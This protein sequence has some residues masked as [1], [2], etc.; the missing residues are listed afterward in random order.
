MAYTVLFSLLILAVGFS[1]G[2]FLKSRGSAGTAASAAVSNSLRLSP[3]QDAKLVSPLILCGVTDIKEFAEFQPLQ[4]K[5]SD[6]LA[7]PGEKGVEASV[8]YRDLLA[9]RWFGINQDAQ[10]N[11]ASL[12]KVAIMIAYY[13][14]AEKNPG[15]LTQ[16]IAYTQAAHD[17][18]K[19]VPNQA[20]SMLTVGKS[21]SADELIKSMIVDSD[22]GAKDLL[23]ASIDQ[24][25]L[26]E[27]Y[28]DLGIQNPVT[29]GA[30]YVISAK[31]YALFFRILYNATY[32]WQTYSE[33][34]LELLAQSQ[35]KDGLAAGIPEG[36]TIAHKFGEYVGGTPDAPE[37]ELHD[38]GIVYN[39]SAPFLIC[40]MT[41]GSD[42][43][44]LQTTISSITKLVYQEVA[45]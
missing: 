42:I 39:K 33:K 10:Y 45:K 1:A 7:T 40:V 17:E 22:N 44:K 36:T 15:T 37:V 43:G 19:D 41:K 25:S 29:K 18:I 24:N 14:E 35:F 12:L 38:C 30:D 2:W 9:G 23:L 13:K 4:K 28:S 11:P 16:K 26:N 27:V 21:Y 8:Y 31:T 3:P 32:L 20:D 5:V 34:A 6:F